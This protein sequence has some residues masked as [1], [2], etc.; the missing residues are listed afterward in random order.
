MAES[1]GYIL[2][3]GEYENLDDASE[4][5]AMIKALHREDFVGHYEAALFTKKDNGKVKIIDTDE[6]SRAHGAEAGAIAG[7]VIGVLFP[8]S[9]LLM[10]AGGGAVGAVIG[11]VS[12]GMP[13]KDIKEVGEML[14]EGEAG[15]IFVGETT[16]EAGVEKLMKKS[17]K[18]MKKEI[19]AEADE[20]KAALNEAVKAA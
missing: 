3:A 15:I 12:K 9:V 17:N 18:V 11:H 19:Q 5:F 2:Y 8:P 4:D 1:D 20:M 16:V 14:D 6:T 7:A 13:R 10:A